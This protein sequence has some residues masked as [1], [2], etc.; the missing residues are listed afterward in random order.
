MVL[1]FWWIINREEK[2]DIKHDTAI[3]AEQTA[4]RL[5]AFF[6]SRISVV[7]H[8]R[9]MM[10]AAESLDEKMFIVTASDI[11]N[12]FP[13]IQVINWIDREGIVR[14]VVP[15][16]GNGDVKGLNLRRKPYSA[17]VLERAKKTGKPQ[18][19]DTVNLLRGG[20]GFAVIY[21]V[22]QSG[23]V[24]GEIGLVFNIAPLIKQ[25]LS[26][27]LVGNYSFQISEQGKTLFTQGIVPADHA[28]SASHKFAVLDREWMITLAPTEAR[29]ESEATKFSWVFV[30]VGLLLSGALSW[31]FYMYLSR[32]DA[33]RESEGKF[34]QFAEYIHEVFWVRD[35]VSDQVT[36]VSR[37]AQGIWGVEPEILFDR[38]IFVNMLHPDD[39]ERVIKAISNQWEG[40]YEE[41]YRIIRPDG[42]ERWI[43]DRAYTISNANSSVCRIVGIAEDITDRKLAQ[44]ALL[45]S[46]SRRRALFE[47]A[48]DS[49]FVSDP[50]TRQILDVNNHALETLGYT[51]EEILKLTIPDVVKNTETDI[52]GKIRRDKSYL[53][54]AILVA[55]DGSEYPVEISLRLVEYEDHDVIQGFIRDITERKQAMDQIIANEKRYRT[56]VENSPFCIHEI[57]LD[58][59]FISMNSAGLKMMGVDNESQICGTSCLDVPIDEDKPKLAE[60]LTNAY[61]GEA[62]LFNF[63][64]AA[65]DKICHFSSSFVPVKDK[66]GKVTKIM[67]VTEDITER[68]GTED[69]LRHAQKMEAVGQLSSG[70]A[71]DF[72]NL[73]MAALGNI[74]FL[75][76]DLSA[77]PEARDHVENAKKAVLRGAELTKRLLAFSRKQKLDPQ[78][79][80]VGELVNGLKVMLIRTLPENIEIDW[81]IPADL[82]KV[83]IDQGQ[84][85][86]AVLNL[87]LNSRDAMTAGGTLT[88]TCANTHISQVQQINL[89]DLKAGDYTTISVEDTGMG[90]Q[91]SHLDKIVDP[92]FT[93][94]GVGE[95]SGLGLSMVYGFVRQ[96]GGHIEI[97][98]EPAVGTKVTLY[99]PRD[100]TASVTDS[101]VLLTP[102]ECPTGNGETILVIEDEPD[103]RDVTIQQLLNLDY[104]VVDGGDGSRV[105]ETCSTDNCVYERNIDLV[106]SDV[107]LPNMTSGPELVD[108]VKK[109]NPS[110]KALLVTGYAQKDVIEN[111]DGNLV[112]PVLGK[113]FTKAE[114]G[115]RISEI[116]NEDAK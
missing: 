64:A 75:E 101:P 12:R 109:C 112:Y 28:F 89:P 96:S 65:D 111:G 62:S 23:R 47:Q 50:E 88:I 91:K 83:V 18:M 98:S 15:E 105:L 38:D 104:K 77:L 49:V 51:K 4:L 31:F 72:N 53:Y 99:L 87:V 71:H 114:L 16:Q 45:E 11:H 103:V 80:H 46:E 74:E 97:E 24:A 54:E 93:T 78:R 66:D 85:E 76:K 27:G 110:V 94:K 92:F 30:I 79:T 32:L 58:S 56:L 43:R 22:L 107:V 52:I 42:G 69:Q 84:L 35:A 36:Y 100:E 34:H 55:K 40:N 102:N 63:R 33:L 67:G 61:A 39:K 81:N 5:E 48:S 113:P 13:G 29:V 20:K 57:D 1:A 44:I 86:N 90:I 68:K 41:E 9:H 8:F 3:T 2:F 82:W 115:R 60:F 10:S 26:K 59:N 6:S 19:T 116:L 25:S 17:K 95:G 70:F 37:G 106:L 21:P 73:L 108:T 7:D 14:W